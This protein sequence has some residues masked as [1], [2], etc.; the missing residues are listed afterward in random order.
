MTEVPFSGFPKES[1]QFL[2][3]L[4]ANN[5]REWFNAHKKDY[6]KYIKETTQAFGEMMADSLTALSPSGAKSPRVNFSPFRIYRDVRFSKDKS[7]YK[8]NLGVL[9]WEGE[10][11]KMEHSSYYFHLEPPNLMLGTGLYQFSKEQLNEYRDSVANPETG[12]E[13]LLAVKKVQTKGPYSIGGQHYKR[14]PRGYDPDIEGSELLLHNGLYAGFEEVIPD[15]LYSEKLVD[16][17]MKIYKDLSP[18]YYW[19][20]EMA[21]RAKEG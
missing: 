11:K 1:V 4:R 5:N 6:E 15:E 17:C 12:K 10:G 19:L 2:L 3:D 20:V 9:F 18:V 13:L 7:P 8:T 21:E 16:Y 14:V